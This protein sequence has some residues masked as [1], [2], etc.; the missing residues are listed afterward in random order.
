MV[1]KFVHLARSRRLIIKLECIIEEGQYVYNNN[2]LK[3][4]KINEIIGPISNPYASAIPLTGIDK[5]S[6]GKNIF[7][8]V[9]DGKYKKR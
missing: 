8:D 1:G 7:A 5:N 4:G 2:N 6:I 3:I 9:K